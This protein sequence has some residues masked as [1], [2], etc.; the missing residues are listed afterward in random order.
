MN[1]ESNNFNTLV[2]QAMHNPEFAHMRPVIEK[3]LL[4]YDIL[5]CMEQSGLLEELVFQ[6][7]T[8][9]RL[10]Y[11][12]NRFSEDIDFAGGQKFSG[13]QLTQ[14]KQ[15][16]EDYL[17]NRYGLEVKVKEP[18]KQHK[19]EDTEIKIDRWQVSVV[20]APERKELPAQRIRIEIAGVP[21]HTRRTASLRS[22]Y[23]FLPDG[24]EHTLI[25]A[26][27]P[28]EIMADKLVSLPATQKYVRYRDIWDLVWLKQQGATLQANLV[29]NKTKDYRLTNFDSLLKQCIASLANNINNKAFAAEMQR[30]LPSDVFNRTLKKDKFIDFLE[31]TLTSLL[32]ELRSQ[33]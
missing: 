4:H 3:E 23:D 14:M 10:C 20:T 7:G 18:G 1:N 5:Y 27:T 17:G 15:C 31:Q 30:F 6:G 16:I 12:A 25:Y 28:D 26:E 24:Y 13:Q 8:C 33:L 2:E 29:T 32:E 21:A 19:P 9:L 11:G 22:N